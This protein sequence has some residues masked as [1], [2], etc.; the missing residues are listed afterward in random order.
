MT[1]RNR[2]SVKTVIGAVRMTSIGLSV[3]FTMPNSRPATNSA[4]HP[5]KRTLWKTCP[6]TQSASVLTTQ[7]R[8]KRTSGFVFC[9]RH[10]SIGRV[11][12]TPFACGP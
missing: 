3:A 9:M 7:N 2:P 12:Y 11:Y 5:S 10:L 4:C 6:A 8:R 1:K